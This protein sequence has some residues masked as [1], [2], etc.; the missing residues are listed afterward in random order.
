MFEIH[1]VFVSIIFRITANN[2]FVDE[3]DSWVSRFRHELFK[4][5]EIIT[6]GIGYDQ[7]ICLS[8]NDC[9]DYFKYFIFSKTKYLIHSLKETEDLSTWYLMGIDG[10]NHE[11]KTD[12]LKEASRLIVTYF[13]KP[14]RF[15]QKKDKIIELIDL[16]LKYKCGYELRDIDGQYV[17]FKHDLNNFY[18]TD[19]MKKVKWYD[20]DYIVTLPEA[21]DLIPLDVLNNFIYQE[22]SYQ[23]TITIFP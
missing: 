9:D 8:E 19:N 7:D 13:E 1:D 5:S 14:E 20:L 11:Y 10:F 2:I 21:K 23:L 12:N 15:P 16:L 17:K 3:I 22:L 4:Q 6:L 18:C